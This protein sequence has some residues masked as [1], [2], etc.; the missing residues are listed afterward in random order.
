MSSSTSARGV[1]ANLELE[2]I[3]TCSSGRGTRTCPSSCKANPSRGGSRHQPTPAP[4]KQT[5]LEEV[6]GAPLYHSVAEQSLPPG[7]STSHTGHSTC[8]T[9]AF[10]GVRRTPSIQL[11]GPSFQRQGLDLLQPSP[12]GWFIKAAFKLHIQIVHHRE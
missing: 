9:I 7:S 10:A 12:E 11:E 8:Q 6:A 4:A 3:Q 2:S 5:P 1:F